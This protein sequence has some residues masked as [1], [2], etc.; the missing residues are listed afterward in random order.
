MTEFLL[1]KRK[2]IA[3]AEKEKKKK[4]NG[5]KVLQRAVEMSFSLVCL[6]AVDASIFRCCSVLISMSSRR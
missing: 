5:Q 3:V 2:K 1:H 4:E 6:G